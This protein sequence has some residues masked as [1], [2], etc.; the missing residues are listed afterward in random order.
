MTERLVEDYL[1]A[2]ARACAG[3]PASARIE[4]L[5]DL[6]EHIAVARAELPEQTEEAVRGILDR[7][8]EPAVIAAEARASLPEAPV[9]PPRFR[10][11]VA[12]MPVRPSSGNTAVVLT[13]VLVPVGLI[14][15]ALVLGVLLFYARASTAP[16]APPAAPQPARPAISLS[17][18]PQPGFL[19]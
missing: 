7:L 4:L 17:V 19:G 14:V 2:V 11:A 18:I 1:A 10:P 3:L 9:A 12:P 6:R 13:A 5:A 16:V 15:L 8:G